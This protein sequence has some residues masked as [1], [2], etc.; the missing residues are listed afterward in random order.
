M[1]TAVPSVTGT[2]AQCMLQPIPPLSPQLQGTI[3]QYVKTLMEVMPKICRLPR[4][5]YGSPGESGGLGCGAHG[6]VAARAAQRSGT[7]NESK[8]DTVGNNRL[9]FPG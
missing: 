4:H 5:E 7:A 1:L 8:L 3:L 9:V 2:C 6:G